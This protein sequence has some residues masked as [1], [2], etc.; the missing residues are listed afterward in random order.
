MHDIGCESLTVFPPA[1]HTVHFQTLTSILL[2]LKNCHTIRF[3][4]IRYLC[5]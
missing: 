2:T 3:R 1:L 4:N 5:A